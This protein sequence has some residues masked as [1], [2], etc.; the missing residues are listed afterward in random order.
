MKRI[1]LSLLV[2]G[3]MILQFGVGRV[4]AKVYSSCLYIT[5]L[6]HAGQL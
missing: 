3:F 5:D 2:A 6:V 4:Y 1:C